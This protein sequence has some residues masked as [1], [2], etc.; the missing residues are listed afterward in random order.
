MMPPILLR[1]WPLSRAK[2]GE[3]TNGGADCET[4]SG[5]PSY[6]MPLCASRALPDRNGKPDFGGG[7]SKAA[8][9]GSVPPTDRSNHRSHARTHPHEIPVTPF[10]VRKP[11]SLSQSMGFPWD[12]AAQASEPTSEPPT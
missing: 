10:P 12:T 5:L 3:L 9:D 4:A 1:W 6:Y 2:T 7:G 11:H 8:G